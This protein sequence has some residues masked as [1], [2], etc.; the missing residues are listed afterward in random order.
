MLFISLIWLLIHACSNRCDFKDCDQKFATS[1]DLKLHEKVHK[2]NV[3]AFL[4]NSFFDTVRE[5][6]WCV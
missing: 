1:K 4:Q 3:H 2:G 6:E 5:I